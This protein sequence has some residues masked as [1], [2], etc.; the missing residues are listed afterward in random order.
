MGWNSNLKNY[1]IMGRIM[2]N[3]KKTVF[4]LHLFHLLIFIKCV[5]FVE[6]F[7]KNQE[8]EIY[9]NSNKYIESF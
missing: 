6:K 7:I 3:V 9:I 2:I 1:E 4:V 8:M 5:V